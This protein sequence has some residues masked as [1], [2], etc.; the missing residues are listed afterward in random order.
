MR[1]AAPKEIVICFDILYNTFIF[2]KQYK[3]LLP[4]SIVTNFDNSFLFYSDILIIV[5]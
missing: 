2:F 3:K 1:E 4:N 5:Y